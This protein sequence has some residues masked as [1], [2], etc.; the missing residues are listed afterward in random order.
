MC[1]NPG[2]GSSWVREPIGRPP[3]VACASRALSASSLSRF[4]GMIWRSC[5]NAVIFHLLA[6]R[7]MSDHSLSWLT[8]SRR[9]TIPSIEL[10]TRVPSSAYH[11][12]ANYRLHEEMLLLFSEARSH[13]MRGSI[14]R[15]NRNGERGSPC[16]I[17]G[18]PS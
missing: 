17:G 16:V 18:C 8:R 2:R 11:L 7:R 9:D 5:R 4:C 13:R 1:P 14:I 6:L 10:A 3:R 12:L 15:S